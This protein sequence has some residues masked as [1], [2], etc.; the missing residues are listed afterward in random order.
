VLARLARDGLVD[1][2]VP[3]QAAKRYDLDRETAG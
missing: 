3:Q 2:D 1:P